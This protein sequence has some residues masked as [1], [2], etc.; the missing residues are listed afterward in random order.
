[1]A[2]SLLLEER[3]T[4]ILNS[5]FIRIICM[6]IVLLVSLAIMKIDLILELP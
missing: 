4:I 2:E 5:D 3:Y 1:M 6:H